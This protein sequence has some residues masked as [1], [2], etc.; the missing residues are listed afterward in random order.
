M[1]LMV[2]VFAI[3]ILGGLGSVARHLLG[4]WQG[5]LPW[6]ILFANTV[7]S[8]IAGIAVSSGEMEIAFVVGLAGGL[9]TFS[10]FAAQTFDL[11]TIGQKPT[12]LVNAILNLTLPALGLLTAVILL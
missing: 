12:A 2:T 6:G 10:T 1:D 11:W 8:V 3:S 4:A 9:S 7:A 5:K